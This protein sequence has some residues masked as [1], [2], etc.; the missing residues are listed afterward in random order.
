MRRLRSSGSGVVLLAIV[1]VFGSVAS[2]DPT[3]RYGGLGATKS[4]FY[5]Q[6]PHGKSPPRLGVAYYTVDR[7][8][9]GRV[10]AFHVEINAKPRFSNRERVTLLAGINLPI[11]ATET[12]INRNTCIVW[13]SAKLKKL[14]GMA[15]AAGT[16]RSGTT[17][18]HMRAERSP[19]C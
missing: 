2:A 7:I 17:T 9:A 18:A 11:D 14:I 19:R 5:A 1:A 4:A 10:V 12:S 16:T 6:N 3:A 13:R 8:R 15:Y